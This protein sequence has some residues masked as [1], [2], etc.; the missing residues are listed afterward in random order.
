VKCKTKSQKRKE[1]PGEGPFWLDSK[2][3]CDADRAGCTG[4]KKGWEKRL[5]GGVREG[6]I[7]AIVMSFTPVGGRKKKDQNTTG[8]FKER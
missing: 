1:G 6:S 5:V 7:Q 8:L 4:A 3:G 2:A